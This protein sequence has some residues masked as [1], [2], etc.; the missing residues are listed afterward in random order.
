M[1][2]VFAPEYIKQLIDLYRKSLDSSKIERLLQI[3]N[4]N[5]LRG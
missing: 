5:P 3:T 2:E 1:F 4:D